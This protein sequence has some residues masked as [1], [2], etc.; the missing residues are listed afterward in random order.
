MLISIKFVF[1]LLDF[2]TNGNL[3]MSSDVAR[4]DLSKGKTSP[5]LTGRFFTGKEGLSFVWLF[6]S[7]LC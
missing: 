3:E 1:L 4:T 2:Q 6:S 5:F 7:A